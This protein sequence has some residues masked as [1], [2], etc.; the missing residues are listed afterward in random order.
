V[1]TQL[2]RRSWRTLIP[3]QAPALRIAPRYLVAALAATLVIA[4][5]SL[6][7]GMHNAA[8]ENQ[9]A[10][11][12]YQD[13]SQLLTV[14]PVPVE[15]LEEQL[16]AAQ[17]SLALLQA[18]T[19]QSTIDPASDD[20]TELLV[21]RA[22]DAGLA[23]VSVARLTAAQ[24]EVDGQRYDVSGLRMTLRAPA[25]APLLWFLQA[26][27]ETDPGLIPSLSSLRADAAGIDAEMVFSV[28]TPAEAGATPAAG[29]P[30]R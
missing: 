6:F 22:Q 10:M 23:V 12:R 17:F 25:Q 29:A 13:A 8:R 18:Q 11:R 2:T 21:R 19:S 1:A 7:A 16:S 9:A 14:P 28:F 30:A 27:Q 5:V 3:G 4:Y 26:L 15:R 20:A 24:Q